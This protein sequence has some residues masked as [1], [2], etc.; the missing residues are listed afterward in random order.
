[1]C[2]LVNAPTRKEY[3]LDLVITDLVT[4]MHVDVLA[5]IA[6]HSMVS[7]VMDINTVATENVERSIWIFKQAKWQ[8]LRTELN[9]IAWQDV[10]GED[11][12]ENV[13]NSQILF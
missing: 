4:L 13:K 6:D 7:M 5:P 12:S 9:A 8:A 1:M 11:F 3:L 10:F 2:Q